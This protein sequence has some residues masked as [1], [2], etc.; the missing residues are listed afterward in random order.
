[1]KIPFHRPELPKDF[2]EIVSD[3]IRSGW[4]TTGDQV[5]EFED[6]L[7][8]YIGCEYVVA[9]NSC[10]AAMH[11]AIAAKDFGKGDKFIVPTFTFVSTI[12]CGEYLSMEPILLDCEPDS[13]NIDL[14]QIE[15]LLK[16]D[17]TIKA[18]IP[19][20]YGGSPLDTKRLYQFA[21]N[22]GVFILEDAAH[23]LGTISLSGKVGNTKY[24]SAFSFY[25][26]KN[27]T[28]L[29]EG[30]AFATNNRKLAERV[31]NLSLHGI[32]KDG[33]RRFDSGGHW[34]YDIISLG[35]KYNMPDI[36]ASFGLWQLKQ[37]NNWQAK[38]KKIVEYYL[39]NLKEL[40]G[41]ILPK[42]G[43]N[44]GNA[45]HLFVIQ[46]N[47]DLWTINR[48]KFIEILKKKGIGLS[49]HYKPIHMMEY[50]FKK[51]SHFPESFPRAYYLYQSVVS[52]PI[53]PSLTQHELEY[54]ITSI[55]EVAED[56]M[57]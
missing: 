49:V 23:A 43:I 36:A 46:L 27:L 20:H 37:I 44:D 39:S 51:L 18:I 17:P 28:T 48:N 15:N 32:T 5:Q 8:K 29:G 1:M 14:D 19:V 42:Y 31:K 33:W 3:S 26:N 4:L 41:I 25:A 34:E 24:G 56:H 30:G 22:Y 11:L 9:V 38:R 35:Y 21:E 53:Y 6:E 57:K 12:E 10:T 55:K 16:Q 54:I 45:W 40:D 2:N 13:F 50:Y 7:K 47:P 52:L